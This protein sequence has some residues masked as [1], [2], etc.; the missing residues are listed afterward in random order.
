MHALPYLEKWIAELD[1]KK[2][3]GDAQRVAGISD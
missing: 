2:E 3:G 1:L